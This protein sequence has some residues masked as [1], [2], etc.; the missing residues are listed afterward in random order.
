MEL[1]ASPRKSL[2]QKAPLAYSLVSAAIPLLTPSLME[3]FIN[4][5]DANVGPDS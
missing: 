5:L 2:R 4:D 3:Y 1:V